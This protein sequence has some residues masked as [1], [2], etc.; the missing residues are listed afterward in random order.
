MPEEVKFA[1]RLL[2]VIV[3]ALVVTA[4]NLYQTSYVTLPAHGAD[5]PGPAEA[6]APAMF[7]PTLLHVFQMGKLIAFAQSSLNGGV[8]TGST[9]QIEKAPLA[10]DVGA[11]PAVE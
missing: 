9:T 4:V 3:F 7:P 10:N 11:G 6:V 2:N 8:A 5:K 1:P